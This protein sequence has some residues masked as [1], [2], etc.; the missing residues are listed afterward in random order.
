MEGKTYRSP[1]RKLLS[2]FVRSR[3]NWKSK[4][5]KGK[6]TIKRLA[7]R[8]QKLQ[9]SRN[10]WRERAERQQ[11]ELRQVRKELA[12]QKTVVA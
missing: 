5:R 9:T 11:E 6:A 8:V 10:C 4:C 1:M 7:S 2:F 12:A 3:D